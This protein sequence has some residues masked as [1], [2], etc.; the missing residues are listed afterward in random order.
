MS[1]IMEARIAA[2]EAR[3]A[4]MEDRLAIYQ[5]IATYGPAADSVSDHAVVG[6]FTEDGTC[7]VGGA[8]SF[9]VS[10]DVDDMILGPMHQG[11]VARGCAHVMSLPHLEL[12]GDA[13]VAVNYSRVYAR[14]GDHWRVERAS[15]N[16][17][18]L[19]RT[20]EGW[21]VKHRLNRLLN[22]EDEA[23][24]VLQAAVRPSDR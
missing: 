19:V 5:L 3:L 12:D 15:A 6:L 13:A 7:D 4:E 8:G 17:W 9:T 21:R 20:G 23:R 18:E 14:H 10:K 16:R 22:G 24:R 1:D 11:Y 2:L